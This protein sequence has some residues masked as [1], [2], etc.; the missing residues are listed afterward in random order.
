MFRTARDAEIATAIYRRLP[1]LVNRS[2]KEPVSVWPVKYFTMFHLTNDSG[3]F[4]T[5]AEL[6]KDAYPIGGNRWKKGEEEFLP[7][8]EGK[9]V[10][11]FD[12]RAASIEVDLARL[13]RPGQPVPAT[14]A[15][16]ENPDW[17]PEP[18]YW[19]RE[20][21]ADSLADYNWVIGFKEITAPTNVRTVIA[22][23]LPR[24]GFG[25]KV[26]LLLSGEDHVSYEKWAPLLVA[27]LNA[28]PLDFV[29]RQKVH[30]QTLNL[31]LVEQFPI[32]P[33]EEYR[34]K[35][36]TKTAD[37]IVREEVLRLTYTAHDM[38]PFARDM[39]YGGPPFVW[40]E[41]ER[42]HS[43]AKL[44]ALYFHLYGVTDPDD[45]TYVF[46][47]FPIV[48]REDKERFGRYLS[49]D[50]TLAYMNAFAAGDPDARVA[51]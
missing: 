29:A 23:V 34:R 22:A 14:I 33:G 43:R 45:V 13:H 40:D 42:R 15:Q 21:D 50:L 47:T 27:N 48:E 37:Q 25:N 30:G 36:G 7:L 39:G 32:V 16:H 3:L 38:E 28:I 19:V 20:S 8:Y 26:P 5:R 6:E 4:R 41:E 1:V 35:F 51:I 12:H 2:G 31:F 24:A 46:S 10:Q 11:A 17:I 49:R 44:D 18:Q 9:M